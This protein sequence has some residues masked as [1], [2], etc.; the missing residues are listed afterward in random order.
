MENNVSNVKIYVI[1]DFQ[2]YQSQATS[3]D[4]WTGKIFWDQTSIP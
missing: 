2:N 1:S 3:H 4:S